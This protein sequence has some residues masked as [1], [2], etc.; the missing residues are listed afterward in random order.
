LLLSV[1]SFHGCFSSTSAFSALEVFSRNALYKSTIYITLKDLYRKLQSNATGTVYSVDGRDEWKNAVECMQ[2]GMNEYFAFVFLA[3]LSDRR[4]VVA[5]DG[6]PVQRHGNAHTRDADENHRHQVDDNEQQQEEAAPKMTTQ[7][8]E[9][10]GAD[11]A[12]RG[13]VVTVDR[14]GVTVAVQVAEVNAGCGSTGKATREREAQT[15]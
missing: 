13:A 7:V 14:E 1:Y 15:T 5:T 11:L 3:L 12:R 8:V 10:V 4:G 2:K 9:S 6:G